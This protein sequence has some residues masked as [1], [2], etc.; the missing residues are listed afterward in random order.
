MASLFIK[1]PETADLVTRVA[2]RTGL[3]KTAAGARTGGRPRGRTRSRATPERPESETGRASCRAPPAATDRTC[4]RQGVLRPDVGRRAR[5]TLF[6]DASALVAIIAFEAERDAFIEAMRRDR[7]PLVVA[8][9]LLGDRVQPVQFRTTWCSRTLGGERPIPPTPPEFDLVAIGAN[10]M[11]LALDAYQTYG[12]RSGHPAKLNMG[13]CFAYACARPT[14]R[15][16]STR[17]TTSFIRT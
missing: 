7:T 9:E 1:D 4:G 17:A 6:V 8:D 14:A 11:R 15:N 10:E 12:K 3:T 5:V 13:D 16:S 2:R